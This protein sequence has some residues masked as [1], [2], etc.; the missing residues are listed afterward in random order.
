MFIQLLEENL[1]SALYKNVIENISSVDADRTNVK[2][3]RNRY[4]AVACVR[5]KDLDTFRP[6]RV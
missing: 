6:F 2:V 1:F 3:T 4:F 5:P